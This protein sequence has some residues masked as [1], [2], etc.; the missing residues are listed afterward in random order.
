M[1][2]IRRVFLKIDG[3]ER[4][5]AIKEIASEM[6]YG[7]VSQRI[8]DTLAGDLMAASRRGIVSRENGLYYLDCRTIADYPRDTLK[9]AFLSVLGN[10]WKDQEDVIRDTASYL[11]FTR[12]GANIQNA[13]KSAING[14]IRQG[15][16]ERDGKEIRRM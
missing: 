15:C 2:A 12:T 7:R 16:I 9:D 14:L 10:T 5:T 11:G 4:G 3:I 1:S 13:F 8:H 6:G